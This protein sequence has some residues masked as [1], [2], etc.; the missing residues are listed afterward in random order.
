MEE[1]MVNIEDSKD[2]SLMLPRKT[3][4]DLMNL[5]LT[6]FLLVHKNKPSQKL[7]QTPKLRLKF[8]KQKLKPQEKDT[9]KEKSIDSN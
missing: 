6:Q 2:Q 3:L 5:N 8:K 1:C 7:K 9:K 4:P